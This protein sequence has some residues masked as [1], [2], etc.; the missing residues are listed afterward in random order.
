MKTLKKRL[1]EK[2]LL[3][4]V[5]SKVVEVDK[6][7]ITN[8]NN[9]ANLSKS[10]I[11]NMQKVN[12]N[13][14]NSEITKQFNQAYKKDTW[15]RVLNRTN[16]IMNDTKYVGK[17]TGAGVISGLT[18][19][20]QAIITD[21]A[22]QMQK[23][24][25][26]K[27]FKNI[28]DLII[29]ITNPKLAIAKSMAETAKENNDI[30]K[31]KD[32]NFIEKLS[33]IATN[34]VS[35]ASNVIIPGKQQINSLNKLI[36]GIVPQAD[37]QLLELNEKISEPSKKINEKLEQERSQHGKVAQTLGDVGQ[38]V[39]NMVPSIATSVVTKNPT[40]GLA[41]MGVS[42][43]G[44]S[45]QEA[46]N[47]GASLDEA[48]RIGDT[49]AMVEIGTEMLTGGVNIFG[50]GALD[51]IVEKG[52]V[53]KVENEVARFLVQQGV[54]IGGE[55][56]E[57]TISDLLGILID[58]GT[59]DKNASYSLKDWGETALTTLLST[60]ILNILTGGM[61]GDINLAR[62]RNDL[63]NN[64]QQNSTN[65]TQ[66]QL[67]STKKDIT[68]GKIETQEQLNQKLAEYGVN[69]PTTIEN[70]PIS[71]QTQQVISNEGKITENR[72]SQEIKGNDK[73]AIKMPNSNY[74]FVKSGD[75][76]I[77][78]FRQDV[79]Q[80]WNNSKETQKLVSTIENIMKDKGVAVRLDADLK[81]SEGN[82][83][84]GKYENGTITINPN[85][86]RA[87]EYIA[88]HELTH[89]IGT[90]QMLDMVQRYRQDNQEFNSKVETLLRNYN[91]TELTEE[92]L[93]DVSAQ[94][95]G[96]QEFINN[97]K[98]TNPNLFQKI[99]NEI[100]YL[101]HQFR[102][103]K[104]QNQFVEDLYNK[105]T[106]AYNSNAELNQSSKYMITGKKG[107]QNLVKNDQ[108][109]ITLLQN[110]NQALQMD[111]RKVN[112]EEIRQKTGWFK[113]KNG[114]WKFRITDKDMTL[115]KDVEHIMTNREY[116]LEDMIKHDILFT[117][118]PELTK[119]ANNPIKVEFKKMGK[120]QRG[121]YLDGEKIIV[122]NSR[123]LELR[124]AKRYIEETLIHEMQHA[125]Q[126][127]EGFEHGTSMKKGFEK[128]INSLGEIEAK[129]TE[130]TFYKEKYLN[131]N[132]TNAPESSKA[133][134]KPL[135]LKKPNIFDKIFSSINNFFEEENASYE[136]NIDVLE[137][138]EEKN[139]NSNRNL[140]DGR[141][142]ENGELEESSSFNLKKDNQGRTLSKEQ[143]EYFKDSKVRDENGNLLEVYHGSDTNFTVFDLTKLGKNTGDKIF[144]IWTT[145]DVNYASQYA[146]KNLI[147]GYVDIKKPLSFEGKTINIDEFSEVLSSFA[148][149]IN[150][151]ILKNKEATKRI[152]KNSV[153]DVDFYTKVTQSIPKNEWVNF[154][155][156]V[157]NKMG[158]D[159]LILENGDNT[160]AVAFES[161]QI[162]SIT[163]ENPT[164]NP[165]I[166]YARQGNTEWQEYLEKNFNTE[167]T[168][169]YGKNVKNG[170]VQ[171]PKVLKESKEDLI[172]SFEK[173][174]ENLNVLTT[175]EQ[176]KAIQELDTKQ[177]DN[178][179]PD[180][181]TMIVNKLSRDK[182]GFKEYVKQIRKLVTNKGVAVDDLFKSTGNKQGIWKYDR[183]L[184]SFSEGQTS[185]GIRQVN[186]KG[187]VVGDSL[188]SIYDKAK[189]DGIT[190]KIL[191][192]YVLNKDNI[193]RSNYEKGIFG[194]S[195]TSKDS[196]RI[197]EEYDKKY[198]KLKDYA[199]EVSDY[200]NNNIKSYLVGNFISEDLYN[201]LR[202]MYPDH[203]PVVRDLTETLE[204]DMKE[205][206][207]VGTQVLKRAKGGDQ[208]VLSTKESLAQQSIN[209]AK[210]FRRNEALKEV[211][212]SIKSD[213]KDLY[214][215]G[216]IVSIDQ[217]TM[218][219][220]NAVG[221]DEKLKKYTA[222]IFE[223]GKAKTFAISKDIYD[224]FTENKYIKAFED[225]ADKLIIG[226]VLKG[227]SST[228]KSLT[229]GKNILY[230]LKNM[231]RD[232][233]DAPIN[234][235]TNFA[236]YYVDWAYAYE[237]IKTNGK[238][239]QEF[240][241]NGG[242]ANTFY[243]YNK[244]LLKKQ[245]VGLP[246]KILREINRQTIGRVEDIN[247]VVEI[248][249]RL[250]EYIATR[251]KGGSIEEALYNSAEIT[252]NFKR[253]G[254]LA[255]LLDK[256]GVPYL[257]S[258]IQ[259]LSKAYRNVVDRKGFGQYANLVI[260][261]SL[262]GIA[263]SIINH[264]IYE[265]DEEY[266]E[267]PDYLKDGYYLIKVDNIPQG[268]Q[269]LLSKFT[270]NNFV[271]IPK[272]RISA[273]L[274]GTAVRIHK[275]LS[276][277]GED[278]WNNYLTDVV[279]NNIG[280]NNPITN[281]IFSGMIQGAKNEAWYGGNI[282][283]ETKYDGKLPVEI[284]DEKTD[285][286]SNWVANT[287]YDMAVAMGG[288]D[289]YKK[290]VKE[291]SLFKIMATPKLSNY[292]IDQYSGFV[293]DFVLPMLTPFAENNAFIDQ[294]TT[295]STL[296][297]S[298]TS[299][300]YD[301][302]NNCYPNSEY[303]TD[304]DK[305]TYKYLT[306]VSKEISDLYKAK[307]EIQ[308]DASLTN[309]EKQSQTYDIQE[310]I[311]TKMEEAISNVEGLK[312]NKNSA[313]F[314]GKEYYKDTDGKWTTVSDDEKIEGIST[315]T[316]TTYRNE[317]TKAT[318]KKRE[319]END[320][321]ATLNKKEKVAIINNSKYT[322]EEK[323]AMYQKS[324][325]NQ[326]TTFKYLN[327][328][329][330][331]N[332]EAY[333][334][335]ISEEIKADENTKSNVKGKTISGSK[336]KNLKAYL[337]NPDNGLSYLE[338]LYIYGRS[339]ELDSAER[340]VI[341][342]AVKKAGLTSKEQKEFYLTLHDVEE[343][344]D[345]RIR[346]K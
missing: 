320:E 187:E 277:E 169:T 41:T 61:V 176:I 160:I 338:K 39:G 155:V 159:G 324:Y 219:I 49:K 220:Q 248:A 45:T 231:S 291:N 107:M 229:T 170:L 123:L 214:D 88:T 246:R 202:E 285:E 281:N 234:S 280:I 7:K 60:T 264:L 67:N 106:Q 223:D 207:N 99:Y 256:Y 124:D 48:V 205:Y 174:T 252:T 306:G 12:T 10:T 11:N 59:V 136:N 283:S 288:E 148:D 308:S 244:G 135:D 300:F 346:W 22:N 90:K 183:Y 298:T 57:E 31:D 336:K 128:Y 341:T 15:N 319:A 164:E 50:K 64:L 224:A 149:K 245:D 73:Y 27:S 34:T 209:Y 108:T 228:F 109:A 134:P 254:E 51:D 235:T 203:V 196:Q 267:L 47:K 118:Y 212:K 91:A 200:A 81:D 345:G 129:D 216:E 84:D 151:P 146:S 28:Q 53:K 222:T 162:K 152:Y 296:K 330:D 213:V 3:N 198:P 26:N 269:D 333:L 204:K 121:A 313:E 113:D 247:Q 186:S 76:K 9:R 157:K 278:V 314:I 111:S 255:K 206:D 251:Q 165:D 265:D 303:A 326:D 17:K 297:S 179:L 201:K 236:N 44:Q 258:S 56:I 243:D 199:K 275:T 132:I 94:L 192:D 182:I 127:I 167:G 185:I 253:G 181:S 142:K 43:K 96:T 332:I 321:E 131:K 294:F 89:A 23:G 315:E 312:L 337:N 335:Y 1:E 344:K 33:G 325:G 78:N 115:K 249:P 144:G 37:E 168:R 293:G 266:E 272:G 153:D 83:A 16:Q 122:I 145:S 163:N 19:I 104:N 95:F 65:L 322:S 138:N 55:V 103:Y 305:L 197:I 156:E 112:N 195:I 8:T 290:L 114:D 18:G 38:V 317:L 268:M 42:A 130:K 92:A 328:I 105:W 69:Q 188:L 310:Q 52:I 274:G 137:K 226:K 21:T 304:T 71:E 309:R 116:D 260:S 184:G 259:G 273:V 287:V 40:L 86:K 302:I 276:Q 225:V 58:K 311:N 284:T 72:T 158:Y 166:R 6:S 77:D 193:A 175:E 35:D 329:T 262:A 20:P 98:N 143:Q 286:F 140:V 29:S 46:L 250:A 70:K 30:L 232:I 125:V 190:Q 97:V 87:F 221:Y 141:I 331:I 80:N 102:G 173:E 93:A 342:N 292:V 2:G 238:Y 339:Y 154:N 54:N 25:N 13:L 119:N 271:R 270:E 215:L 327:K 227:A 307:S 4:E 133:N 295:S 194:E 218:E 171:K 75:E 241:N 279:L 189:K 101:W 79:S 147:E 240:V 14:N 230:A 82:I 191:D 340:Q 282:Y 239:W 68:Q 66:E 242:N 85:S 257:N 32:K 211:Y 217:A 150:K 126:N 316:F 74:K 343:L 299:K 110:Y 289:Y 100:K 36:G 237:Q 301:I 62:N 323:K 263:P 210:A 172:K 208:N 177:L 117:M 139:K 5:Q 180:T 178:K 261:A 161:N 334:D 63:R 24:Q 233:N 120:N 318:E